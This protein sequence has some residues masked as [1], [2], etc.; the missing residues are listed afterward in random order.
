VA[1]LAG[2]GAPPPFFEASAEDRK[3]VDAAS[4]L[5]AG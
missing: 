5:G 1:G 2:V 4:L 3:P